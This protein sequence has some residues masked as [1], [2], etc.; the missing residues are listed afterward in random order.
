M[1]QMFV[2]A[3]NVPVLLADPTTNLFEVVSD[4]LACS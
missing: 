2:V 4:V 1:K 3:Q